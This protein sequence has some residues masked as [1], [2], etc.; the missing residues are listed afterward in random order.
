MSNT[1][2]ISLTQFIDFS[3]KVSTSARINFVKGVKDSPEYS[4]AIDYWKQLRDEIRRIHEKGLPITDL[5]H[6]SDNVTEAKRKNYIKN[7]R[8]YVNFIQKHDV[9]FFDT[10]KGFWQ[11]DNLHIRT[12]PELGL[13][14]NGQNYLVK[15]YYKV[16]NNNKVTKK[17]I[18]TTLTLMKL[19]QLEFAPPPDSKFAVI[20]LQKGILHES[21]P[22]VDSDV[23][24]LKIEAGTLLDIWKQT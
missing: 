13:K 8:N 4:P 3:T 18:S 12:T 11:Y 15:N 23:L 24:E 19:S 1:A 21:K 14:I 10:G 17:N 7:I 20:N 2:S 9:E 6:L 16:K 5:Y 22:I